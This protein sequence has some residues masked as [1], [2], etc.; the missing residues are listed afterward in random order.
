MSA[1]GFFRKAALE[2]LSTPEKLDQLIKITSLN[3][4]LVLSM[5]FI[6]ISGALVWG[7]NGKVKTKINAMGI[8]LG[9]EVYDVVSTSRGQLVKLNVANGDIINMGEVI[10]EIEQPDLLLQIEA[11]RASLSERRYELDQ[12][13]AFGNKDSRIQ[14][15]LVIKQRENIEQEIASLSKR[16]AQLQ[17]EL[18]VD[19]HLLEKGLITK[20]QVINVERQIDEINNGIE[21]FN[22]NKVQINSQE[23]SNSFDLDNRKNSISQRIG[24]QKLRLEQLEEQYEKSTYIKSP[25]DGEVIELLTSSGMMVGPGSALFKIKTKNESD[26]SLRGV[27]Y[28]PAQEGKK[29]TVGMQ[30]LVVPSTIQPQE[31]GYILATVRHV[32]EF[33]VTQQG[34]MASMQNDQLVNSMLRLGAPFEVVVEFHK[35]PSTYSGYSW[36]SSEGPEIKI[37]TGTSCIGKITVKEE[38]PVAM[39]VPA[40]KDFFDLY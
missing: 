24:Q 18:V 33:P 37:N 34:M 13:N 10:A 38:T 29:I 15:E 30:A 12:I 19:R 8:L 14:G 17:Q 6:A 21:R 2:K 23:L 26:A 27:L 11:A 5:V 32:S 36:T 31:H 35:D 16:K 20:T 7:I 28:V 25:H 22:A 3:S 1:P 9:G 39:I 40:F 4:W